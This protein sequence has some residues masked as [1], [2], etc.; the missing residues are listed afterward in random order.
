M[1]VRMP[2][3]GFYLDPALVKR[4]TA[5]QLDE[6]GQAELADQIAVLVMC[7]VQL[8]TGVAVRLT[9]VVKHLGGDA[10]LVAWLERFPGRPR[11]TA[12]LLALIDL[13]NAVSAEPAVVTAL[14]ELRTGTP[15]PPDLRPYLPPDTDDE[16]LTDL[17][18][19]I[20]AL[21]GDDRLDDAVTL[22][23]A[24]AELFRRIARRARELSPTLP[25]LAEHATLAAAAVTEAAAD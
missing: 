21:A 6:K 16:A 12:R 18:W 24:S 23:L 9:R 11:I 8:P 25:D 22:A 5:D 2:T 14:T 4:F 10:A 3:P 7:H 15:D 17:A 13:L 20:E 19:H 1:T